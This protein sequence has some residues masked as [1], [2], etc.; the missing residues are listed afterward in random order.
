MSPNRPDTRTALVVNPLGTAQAFI[1]GRVIGC[2]ES[3][4]AFP[5]FDSPGQPQRFLSDGHNVR[6]IRRSILLS[7]LRFR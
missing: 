4:T 2:L 3:V 5:T 6:Y 7:A 1:A